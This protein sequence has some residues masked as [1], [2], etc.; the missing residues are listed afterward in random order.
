MTTYTLTLLR[1][2][3]P[4]C[5]WQGDTF[6]DLSNHHWTTHEQRLGGRNVE[7]LMQEW[8]ARWR[9]Q[10]GTPAPEER[11]PVCDWPYA[12]SRDEG[13]VPGDCSYLPEPGTP[14]HA[15]IV[16][17]RREVFEAL[18]QE[19]TTPTALAVFRALCVAAQVTPCDD[20]SARLLLD[21]L[22][23]PPDAPAHLYQAGVAEAVQRWTTRQEPRR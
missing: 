5:P 21:R 12:A 11:C 23:V 3:Q 2:W 10:E 17:R 1:C 18:P 6:T 4:T 19:T 8:R 15:R 16:A 14:E 9:A 7:T 13:C 20:L 22:G